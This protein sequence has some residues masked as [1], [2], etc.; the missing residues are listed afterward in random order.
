MSLAAARLDDA[1]RNG[2]LI[3]DGD[4]ELRSHVLNAVRISLPSE[5]HRYDRPANA[6]KGEARKK[7]PIDA[8]TG[9]LM[10]NSVAVDEHDKPNAPIAI[11]GAPR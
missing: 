6:K 9:L 10:G 2:W 8:L 3:H 5:K 11:W 7:Y 1:I 4:A